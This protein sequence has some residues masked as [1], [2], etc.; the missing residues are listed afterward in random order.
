SLFGSAKGACTPMI[1]TR[2]WPSER[3][4]SPCA[5]ACSLLGGW[6]RTRNPWCGSWV[7]E[8]APEQVIRKVFDSQHTGATADVTADAQVPM[9]TG[10]LST[11]IS[12]RAARTAASGLV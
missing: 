6:V 12:L 11:S 7:I 3:M 9:I 2:L 1:A 10:T 4:N 5:V 8:S